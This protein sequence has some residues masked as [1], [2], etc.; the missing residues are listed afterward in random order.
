MAGATAVFSPTARRRRDRRPFASLRGAELFERSLYYSCP[1]NDEVIWRNI[2]SLVQWIDGV[3][4][5]WLAP[6]SLVFELI[7]SSPVLVPS[8]VL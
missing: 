1:I 3:D 6:L 7:Y 4:W 5:M 8:G 2:D